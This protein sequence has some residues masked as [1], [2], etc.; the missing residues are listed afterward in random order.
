MF[1]S[2]LSPVLARGTSNMEEERADLVK[3][4]ND[5]EDRS[6]A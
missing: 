1:T 2:G 4:G 5:D 6:V 3:K